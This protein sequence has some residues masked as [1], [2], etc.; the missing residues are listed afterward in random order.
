[1]RRSGE[2]VSAGDVPLLIDTGAD[3]TLLPRAAVARLGIEPQPGMQYELIG[4]DGTPRVAE[5][6]ELDMLFLNRA[7]RGRYLLTDDD[8]GIL[9]RD[10]LASLRLIFDGP[11]QEW[12]ERPVAPP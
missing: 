2:D 3:V 4:F 12:S 11:A 7:F 8:H 1:L 9:G 6:I 5:A 10:V